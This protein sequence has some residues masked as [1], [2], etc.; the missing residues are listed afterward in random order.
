MIAVG[1]QHTC[2]LT[3]GHDIACWGDNTDFSIAGPDD[4]ETMPTI[5]GPPGMLWTQVFTGEHHTC[6]VAGNT[7]HLW[8][9]GLDMFGEVGNNK[10]FHDRPVAVAL[11]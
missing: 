5:I 9:W 3:A 2:A 1:G 8:C 6:A 7:G 10:R 11:P 4:L